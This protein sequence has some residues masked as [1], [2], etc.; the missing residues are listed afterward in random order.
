[1]V[2]R[3]AME[4]M[5]QP[6][7]PLAG[8]GPGEV[9][10]GVDKGWDYTPG[11]TVADRMRSYV[12]TRM[13]GMP[14]PLAEALRKS[15]K[16]R[17]PGMLIGTPGTI[18][19]MASQSVSEAASLETWILKPDGHFPAAPLTERSRKAL[20]TK[21]DWILF[22]P[23][24]LAKQLDHHP[25]ISAEE[26]R[27]VLEGL[28]QA[29]VYRSGDTKL[30]LLQHSGRWYKLILKATASGEEVFLTSFIRADAK[31]LRKTRALPRA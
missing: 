20:G 5:K 3:G 17:L 15:I 1:M 10:P 25:E 23:E 2:D 30:A 18:P 13:R 22:S 7:R 24:T 28:D 31:T 26:Y 6:P 14:Q 16:T 27:T 11:A 29:E 19:G 21:A 4:V 8:A 12:N 9:L